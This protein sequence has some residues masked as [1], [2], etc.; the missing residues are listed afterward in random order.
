MLV[1]LCKYATE[2]L[3]VLAYDDMDYSYTMTTTAL[4]VLPY[5]HE[6]RHQQLSYAM[7]TGT[8]RQKKNEKEE[9]E[10]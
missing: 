7:A 2:I 1:G 8:R 6:R 9:A 10:G 5:V 3:Y 4:R